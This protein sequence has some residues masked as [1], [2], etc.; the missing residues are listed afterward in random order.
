MMMKPEIIQP[1]HSKRGIEYDTRVNLPKKRKNDYFDTAEHHVLLTRYRDKYIVWKE[2]GKVGPVPE[3]PEIIKLDMWRIIEG[4]LH[5]PKNV[6]KKIRDN[7][8]I[9]E[10]LQLGMYLGILNP[11]KYYKANYERREIRVFFYYNMFL[12]IFYQAT[13][14]EILRKYPA[15]GK[16]PVNEL[17]EIFY[18]DKTFNSGARKVGKVDNDFSDVWTGHTEVEIREFLGE[19]YNG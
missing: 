2:G 9:M 5:G 14:G 3:V 13:I 15:R 17:L 12:K 7:A 10:G 16:M 11:L 8:H 4:W 18:G 6:P 19:E 1:T